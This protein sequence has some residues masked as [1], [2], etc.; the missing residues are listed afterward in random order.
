MYTYTL[1][2]KRAHVHTHRTQSQD[3]KGPPFWGPVV[4][5]V[6]W[7]LW[8]CPDGSGDT[9][10]TTCG[11]QEVDPQGSQLNDRRPSIPTP[12]TPG[13]GDVG[14]EEEPYAQSRHSQ[15]TQA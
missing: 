12:G 14:G 10:V 2:Y 9:P 15:P 5:G 1:M 8:G 4:C 6:K 11:V 7:R 13:G 3:H